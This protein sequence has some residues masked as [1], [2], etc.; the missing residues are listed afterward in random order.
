MSF[1]H[2]LY[3]LRRSECPRSEFDC[4]DWMS[5]FGNV[6]K[7][8]LSFISMAFDVLFI[9]QHYVLYRNGRVELP[10]QVDS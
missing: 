3:V 2:E 4:Y 6:V 10:D 5:L 9:V 1:G 7:V 8:G